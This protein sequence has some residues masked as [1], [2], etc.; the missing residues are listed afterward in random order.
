MAKNTHN[1]LKASILAADL[2]RGE[3]MHIE[4][5]GCDIWIRHPSTGMALEIA[6]LQ[7]SN[8]DEL[9]DA[10]VSVFLDVACDPADK[11]P[12]FGPDDRA[13]V[14]RLS[15]DVINRVVSKAAGVQVE[16]AAKN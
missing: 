2:L 13:T 12:L 5:W 8:S 10:T 6:R 4:E 15:A 14:L 3:S 7:R 9:A 11:Q 1:G 16:D